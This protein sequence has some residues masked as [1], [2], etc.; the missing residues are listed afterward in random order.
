[1]QTIEILSFTGVSPYTITICDTTF[2]YCYVVATGVTSTPITVNVPMLLQSA[3]QLILKVTDANSC[4]YFQI[5]T[6]V[7][8]TPTP[9]PT[10]TPSTSMI[11]NCNCITFDNLYGTEDYN[12]GFTQCDG[13][14]LNTVIYSGTSV[15]YCGRQPFADPEVN[16][17]IGLPCVDNT[18]PTPEFTQSSTPTPTPTP[19]Q[20]PSGG[21]NYLLQEDLF[22]LLQEDGGRIIIT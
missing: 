14:V 18:C 17:S 8:P 16:I 3:S 15:Y 19:S 13:I 4:D 1:M 10:P 9:T 20:T 2:S 22:Y 7:S 12:I 5:K 11:V 6:C 21:S